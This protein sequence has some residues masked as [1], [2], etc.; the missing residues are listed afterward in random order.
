MLHNIINQKYSHNFMPQD[1]TQRAPSRLSNW[2][3]L[4][5]SC[6]PLQVTQQRPSPCQE[7]P[8]LSLGGAALE[9]RVLSLKQ[10]LHLSRLAP[11]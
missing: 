11:A 7:P 6:L 1:F 5:F 2:H 8:P 9:D 4:A 10:H 3:L